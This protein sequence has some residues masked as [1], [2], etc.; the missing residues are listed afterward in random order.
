MKKPVSFLITAFLWI[1]AAAHAV[2]LVFGFS[3]I[4]GDFQIPRW[5]SIF[6]VVVLPL[7]AIMLRREAKT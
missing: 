1:A 5:L 4:I 3:I 6:P 2:R 7:L